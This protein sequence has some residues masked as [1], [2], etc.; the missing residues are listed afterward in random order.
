MINAIASEVTEE[1]LSMIR[2][3]A[4]RVFYDFDLKDGLYMKEKLYNQIIEKYSEQLNSVTA[5]FPPLSKRV[6]DETILG[7]QTF[8]DKEG[9]IVHWTR[10]VTLKFKVSQHVALGTIAQ[11]IGNP[12][13]IGITEPKILATG[14]SRFLV[15]W[16]HQ[17]S[18]RGNISRAKI[19]KIEFVENEFD[20]DKSEGTFDFT[21][22]LKLSGLTQ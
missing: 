10:D 15:H 6:A 21:N 12:Q 3:K 16:Q 1:F 9:Q 20:S 22:F 11:A 7:D 13:P 5:N 2:E 8:I 14:R 18:T 17:V 19:N 4:K